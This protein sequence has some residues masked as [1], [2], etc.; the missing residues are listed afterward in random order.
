MRLKVDENLPKSLVT[1]FAARGHDAEHVDDENM[2]GYP[3]PDI[4]KAAQREERVL[5]TLDR[6]FGAIGREMRQHHGIIILRPVRQDPV[7]VEAV[8]VALFDA[9]GP[10]DCVNRVVI[11][12]PEKFRIVPTL[13]LI[14]DIDGP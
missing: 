11:A 12:G 5:L 14:R 10:P 3:D 9:A 8:L 7:A 4:W 2:L 6:G 13:S 1:W